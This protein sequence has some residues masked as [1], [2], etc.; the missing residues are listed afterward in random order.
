MPSFNTDCV[1]LKNINYKDS[2]KIFTVYSKDRG[3]FI[4]TAKGVRKVSSKRSGNL[5]SLNHVSLKLSEAGNG[6]L[7]VSEAMLKNSF[8][9]IKDDLELSIK[10]YYVAELID[11]FIHG[12]HENEE[13]FNL[14]LRALTLLDTRKISSDVAV[15]YFEIN[16]MKYLGYAITFNKCASCEREFSGDWSNYMLNFGLGGL[17]CGNCDA[18]GLIITKNDALYLNALDRGK[19]LNGYGNYDVTNGLI[20]TYIR[21]TLE[22]NLKTTRVYGNV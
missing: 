2:D 1:I 12:D 13:V 18:R 17:I 3:K 10:G 8:P 11:K 22:D 6:Y 20:K 4:A 21:D 9:V 19:I 15:N 14:L 5:D 16:L 7:Y